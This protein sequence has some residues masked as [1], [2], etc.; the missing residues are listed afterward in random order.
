MDSSRFHLDPTMYPHYINNSS[1][2]EDSYMTPMSPSES[3]WGW[4]WDPGTD[5]YIA[6]LL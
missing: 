4:S 1:Q 2:P 3:E 5:S 6:G